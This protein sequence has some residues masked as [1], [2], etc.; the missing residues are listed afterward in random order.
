MPLAAPGLITDLCF[1]RVAAAA[2]SLLCAAS[3]TLVVDVGLPIRL[4]NEH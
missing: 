1:A 3:A 2:T 4:P